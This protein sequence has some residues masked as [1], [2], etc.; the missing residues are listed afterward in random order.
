MLKFK[1]YSTQLDE[2]MQSIEL[3]AEELLQLDEVLDTSERIKKRQQ[4][5]RRKGRLAL[6]RKIQSKRLATTD[7]LKA[8]A[9]NRAKSLLI[10]RLF[11]GRSRS[12]IPLSQ[13]AQVD[14]KLAMLK[15]AVKRI[16]TKL[17]RRVK[18]QDIARKSGKSIKDTGTNAGAL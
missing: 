5:V 8:R 1:D 11:Q 17:L 15:G 16:S 10:K 6:A 7:R 9:R 14:K 2:V 3:S 12:Q 18:Q 13:R 4:F